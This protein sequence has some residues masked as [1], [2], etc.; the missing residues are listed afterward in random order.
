MARLSRECYVLE[1]IDGTNASIHILDDGQFLVGSRNRWITPESDNYGFAKWAYGH[2]DELMTLG[3]GR[4]FGEWFGLGIQRGYG[5]SERRFSLFNV[6]RW[7]LHGETPQP[8]PTGNP[9]Q[10][11]MQEVLP[12]CVGLV[13]VL[14]RG[15][16]ST[17]QVDVILEKLRQF[18][19]V[20]AP[21]FPS[22]EGVVVW[23]VAANIGFKKTFDDNHKG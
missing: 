13:P 14:W 11:K 1:K 19:S 5:L 23:H 15:V 8:I 9:K 21:G 6:Q 22:P 12:P 18:G 16:F 10:V 3:P 7:V 2:K 17:P 4:H 20:A